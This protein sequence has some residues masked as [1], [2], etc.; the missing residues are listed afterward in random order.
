MEFIMS[1]EYVVYCKNIPNNNYLIRFNQATAIPIWDEKNKACKMSKRDAET[2][3][4]NLQKIF[5]YSADL[6]FIEPYEDR[7]KVVDG[8]KWNKENSM[9]WAA[10]YCGEKVWLRLQPTS[11][12]VY[13][14]SYPTYA[15]SINTLELEKAM[16]RATTIVAMTKKG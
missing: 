7:V 10:N 12:I 8:V 13:L 9:E 2:A 15:W 16:S 11:W 6:Y 1:E 14:S 3:R 5:S 4:D